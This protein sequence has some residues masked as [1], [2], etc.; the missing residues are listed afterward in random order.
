[1]AFDVAIIGSGIVG[2]ACAAALSRE[3][4]SVVVIDGNEIASGSTAAGMGHIVVMD[5]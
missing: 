1:M 4:L 5:D 3:N 2:A